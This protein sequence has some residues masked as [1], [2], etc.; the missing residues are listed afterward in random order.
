MRYFLLLSLGLL[1]S[2]LVAQQV[3][4]STGK[5][6]SSPTMS[7]EYSVG[8]ISTATLFSGQSAATQGFIQ[9]NV[10]VQCATSA[11]AMTTPDTLRACATGSV[12][13]IHNGLVTL[14]PNDILWFILHDQ[15]SEPPGNI[16]AWST[17]PVFGFQPGMS[18]GATYYISAIVGNS[19][20]AAGQIDLND[21]CLD[22]APG[23]PV[24]FHAAP[25]ATILG[26]D[27]V[28]AGTPTLITATGGGAYE[29][30]NHSTSP[31]FLV[32]PASG[33][34]AYAVTVT[35]ASGCTAIAV[36]T[37]FGKPVPDVDIQPVAALCVGDTAQLNT[38]G[39]ATNFT[40]NT[41][42]NT[43]QITVVPNQTGTYTVVG[44]ITNDCPNSASI[45]VEVNSPPQAMASATEEVIACSDTIS[46][47]GNALPASGS[48]QWLSLGPAD[49]TQD[50]QPNTLAEGLI[51]GAN[52]FVWSVSNA[53]CPGPA[54]DTVTIF[55][56]NEIPVLYPDDTLTLEAKTVELHLLLND[57]IAQLPDYTIR[58]LESD[59]N[60]AWSLASNGT[61]TFEPSMA[62]KGAAKA[63]YEI[64][65]ALCPDFCAEASVRILVKQP[66]DELGETVA[67]TPD[68]DGK[69]ETLIFD[70]LDQYPDNNIVIFN[71][72]G[73]RVYDAKPYQNDWAGTYKGKPL[74]AGTYYYILNLSGKDE[75]VWGNVLIVR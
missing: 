61:L 71:R 13:A 45:T 25:M 40:W 67:I 4:N 33:A 26:Q 64:C 9:P 74:P 53:P 18:L 75:S 66:Q 63:V 59:L 37:I 73:Q 57:S 38:T 54:R 46:L 42:A 10:N 58:L 22:I 35:D 6:L 7:V 49:V 70:Y 8:E 68:G 2:S 31:Q 44:F 20:G 27:T 60:G 62:F 36:D 55:Y 3:V 50:N 32:Y 29:W 30:F 19:G 39:N 23:T 17:T 52:R 24:V 12:T 28:C 48:G 69:N 16:L 5:V 14:D 65:N 34:D 56:T 1:T 72:W 43:D 21:P 47:H 51:L 11:G 15:S 41:G